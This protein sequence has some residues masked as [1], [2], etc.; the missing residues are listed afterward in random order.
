MR[1]YL[2]FDLNSLIIMLKILYSFNKY[3]SYH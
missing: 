1:V 3:I 2:E